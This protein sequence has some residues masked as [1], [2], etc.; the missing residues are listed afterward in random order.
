VKTS[1]ASMD[2]WLADGATRYAEHLC[3][4][5]RST[6]SLYLDAADRLKHGF[7]EA[8]V[9]HRVEFIGRGCD[10]QARAVHRPSIG[11]FSRST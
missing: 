5:S 9:D 10:A 1:K 2:S 11:T 7:S 4:V 8:Q 6:T 3:R